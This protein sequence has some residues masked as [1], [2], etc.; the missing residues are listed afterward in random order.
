ML[1]P[2]THRRHPD[3]LHQRVIVSPLGWSPFLSPAGRWRPQGSKAQ[4][5]IPRLLALVR[6]FWVDCVGLTREE[7]RDL[8][9]ALAEEVPE[10]LASALNEHLTPTP[11]RRDG[12]L[13]RATSMACLGQHA[14]FCT[15]A[16]GPTPESSPSTALV[17]RVP[18]DAYWIA[19]AI[20][21][22]PSVG[23]RGLR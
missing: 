12:P 20:D 7:L 13:T 10:V 19:A 11:Q 1:L 3:V 9:R 4:P 18:P 8:R 14:H 22:P 21:L 6:L 5:S 16:G 2:W 15:A 23:R 17:F